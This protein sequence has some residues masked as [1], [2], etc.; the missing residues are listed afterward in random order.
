M[1]GYNLTEFTP[2]VMGENEK[3]FF[4]NMT[5]KVTSNIC[6]WLKHG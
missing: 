5:R 6:C 4:K 3:L 1:E 2:I